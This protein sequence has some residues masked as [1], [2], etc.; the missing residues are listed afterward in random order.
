MTRMRR[1]VPTSCRVRREVE[2][3]LTSRREEESSHL[4]ASKQNVIALLVGTTGEST[5]DELLP[6]PKLLRVGLDDLLSS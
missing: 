5:E 2:S 4:L 1:A 3:A 6:C